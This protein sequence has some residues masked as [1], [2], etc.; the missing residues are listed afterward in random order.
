MHDSPSDQYPAAPPLLILVPAAALGLGALYFLPV[1][2]RAFTL[3]LLLIALA[4][5]WRRIAAMQ[6]ILW[7]AL[8]LSLL[9]LLQLLGPALTPVLLALLLA[10]VMEPLVSRF[11]RRLSRAASAGIVLLLVLLGVGGLLTL[12]LPV[13]V[14]ET[15]DLVGTVPEMARSFENWLQ[16]RLPTL[17]ASFGLDG[18]AA[19]EWMR[20][21]APGLLEQAFGVLGRGGQLLVGGVT[22]LVSSLLNLFLVPIFA[23][24]VSSNACRMRA[25]C[26]EILLE[27][28]KPVTQ[29]YARE[30][31]RI[32]SGFFR[33]QLAVSS[34]VALLTWLG[35]WLSDIP[36]PLLLG[37]ATGLL[38]VIPLIGV[39]SMFVVTCVV[40]LFGPEPWL[41][42]LK[43]VAVFAVVQG[44]ES[45][46][47]TPRILGRSV[48]VHPALALLALLIFGSV[49]GL[50]GMILA[51]P[52]AAVLLYFFGDLNRAWMRR[53]EQLD[54]RLNSE[55]PASGDWKL[56]SEREAEEP[57]T[58]SGGSSGNDRPEA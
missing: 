24:A 18:D 8:A 48:G 29:R 27:D 1:L 58:R 39:G 25:W 7:A 55:E 46:L 57:D 36:Y 12:S 53:K 49:L 54:R 16:D 40:S 22:G 32:F 10:Y 11:N 19:G 28:W 47:I 26:D 2:H 30:F 5:P 17:L 38:N 35:L 56:R 52:L 31:N 9:D 15:S 43:V 6:R 13:L 37:V 41:G 4:W 34:I 42:L 50:P 21:K 51:V 14:R 45:T 20:A 23:V 33:G 3:G 44:L